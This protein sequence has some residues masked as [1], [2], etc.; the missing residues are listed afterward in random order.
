MKTLSSLQ[1]ARLNYEPKFPLLFQDLA[2]VQIKV[3]EQKNLP[4]TPAISESFP[5]L[6][7]SPMLAFSK[8]VENISS[9]LKVG[10]VF[11][12][13]QASG[14]HNVIIGL[15]DALKKL[16]SESIL[17]G[18]KNGPKGII[19]NE[20]IELTADILADYRNQGGFDLLGSGRTKIE[21]PQQFKA[22]EMTV[23][24]LDLDGLVIIGG[25][26]SNTNAAFLSEY[27]YQQNIK[28]K[29]IGVPKT[30]DGDLK[31][32]QIEISFGFDT[33]CKVYSE[34]IG[35]ILR[36]ALSAEK[37][38]FFIKL[39]GRSASHIA[40][41]CA[42]QTH[43]NLTLIS[44]EIAQKKLTLADVT[45]LISDVICTRSK[46]KKDFGVILIPEG[47][48]EFIPECKTLIQEL[49]SLLS[50]EKNYLS[51]FEKFSGISEKYSFIHSLLTPASA[52][53]FQSFPSNIK[54]QLFLDRDPH[55]NIQVSKIESERL[56]IETVNQELQRRKD[57]GKYAG[58]FSPQPV[59]LGYEGR[60]SLPSNFDA[61]YCYSLGFTAALLINHNSTGYM[62]ALEH[63]NEAVNKWKPCGVPL[64]SMMTIEQR[65][66]KPKPVI[67]KALVNLSGE[68][69]Q[70]F[71]AQR[72]V[73]ALQ[74]E[75]LYPG[76]IQ[77]FGPQNICDVKTITLQLENKRV[78]E[79]L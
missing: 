53:C 75:F 13:G 20:H 18:F 9:F 40:L 50:P 24:N 58:K 41:E 78:S 76:P 26:D 34:I 32:D 4:P 38:Y 67:S 1:K 46:Q 54:T 12:G 30:I 17:L 44:E 52:N 43:P 57:L 70:T 29:V 45:N 8:G 77:F 21:T 51:E 47:I 39:M 42:L 69:F 3:D 33:A 68:P 63:L 79:I 7:S 59:F 60:C 64:V 22:A 14:G 19:D 11:S 23:Q 55:G 37:Y 74:D 61:D 2:K 25:D 62:A 48:I 56:F 15:F 5:G 35:N 72:K 27:F 36:D 65:H 71:D 16:N 31:N 6:I 10:V 28:T 49:N 66:G 73:W